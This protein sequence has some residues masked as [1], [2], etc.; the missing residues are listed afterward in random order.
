VIFSEVFR[1]ILD[2]W[3]GSGWFNYFFY[4]WR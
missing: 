2:P 3:C 4:G 1:L